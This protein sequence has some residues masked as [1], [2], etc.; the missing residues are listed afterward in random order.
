MLLINSS[1]LKNGARI[2]ILKGNKLN[3]Q[4][5]VYPYTLT[6]GNVQVLEWEGNREIVEKG[7]LCGWEEELPIFNRYNPEEWD[8]FLHMFFPHQYQGDN[9]IEKGEM[10]TEIWKRWKEHYLNENQS[11]LKSPRDRMSLKLSR[12]PSVSP[13]PSPTSSPGNSPRGSIHMSPL[14]FGSEGSNKKKGDWT[15]SSPELSRYFKK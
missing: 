3:Y 6:E 12:S 1:W 5:R 2:T 15:K 9:D 10:K 14:R 13:L 11:D 4:G 7:R 8:R